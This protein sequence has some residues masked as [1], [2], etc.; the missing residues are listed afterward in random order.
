MGVTCSTN[1]NVSNVYLILFR[2]SAIK[3]PVG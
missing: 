1:G 3:T 2:K